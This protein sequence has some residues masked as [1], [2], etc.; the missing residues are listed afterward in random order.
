MLRKIITERKGVVAIMCLQVVP[1]L[2]FPASSYSP[3]TQEWWLPVFLSVLVLVSTVKLLA[4][5]GDT[6]WPWYLISFS[7]GFNIISRLMMLMPHAT[8]FV[9]GKQ[10]INAP[11]IAITAASMALSA[12]VIWYSDL[13]EVRNRLTA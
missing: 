11:Y 9:A 4:G 8:V 1:L 3:K 13:P 2:L 7:Q 5:K 10:V 6:K 12:F